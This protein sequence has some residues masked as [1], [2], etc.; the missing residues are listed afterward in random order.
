MMSENQSAHVLAEPEMKIYIPSRGRP[1][2]QI[3]ADL[4]SSCGIKFHIV[5]TTD[6]PT[7]NEYRARFGF[8]T[9]LV[10]SA[11]DIAT[12][13]QAILNIADGKFVMMDD[14]LRF[15][16]RSRDGKRFTTVDNYKDLTTML[17]DIEESLSSFA[18][19]GLVDKF[20]AQTRPRKF[21]TRGRYNQVLAY[22]KKHFPS[23]PP[24]FRTVT[25]QEHDFHLQLGADGLA[26]CILTEWSKD[27]PYYAKGGCS[28][29]RTAAVEKK[30]FK[31]IAYNFPDLVKIVPHSKNISGLAIRVKW[32][33]AV[34]Q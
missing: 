19:V 24:K 15:Y 34:R 4:L 7:L 25:N 8:R 32:S 29:W 27:A 3:T 14:D 9:V 30:G 20:M 1:R 5:C 28:L 26:P 12:K 13:R 23:P 16:K 31:Q 6:D 17:D 18:H 10:V 2:K 22:N 11:V 21:I 33:K